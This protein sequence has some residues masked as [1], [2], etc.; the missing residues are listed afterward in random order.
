MINIILNTIFFGS[1]IFWILLYFIDKD[2]TK[3]IRLILGII[4][5]IF[6]YMVY[7]EY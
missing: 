2:Y 6:Y 7:M 4:F 5:I 1:A 3:K